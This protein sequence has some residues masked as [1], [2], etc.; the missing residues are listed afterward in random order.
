MTDEPRVYK[1]IIW[2]GELPGRRVTILANSLE[3]A[4]EKLEAEHGAGHVYS[5][6]N[7]EDMERPR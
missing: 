1:A 5:L 7:E 6:Y 4:K 2:V 3:E